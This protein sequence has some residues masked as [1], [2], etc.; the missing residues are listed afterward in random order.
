MKGVQLFIFIVSLPA[1][2]AIGFDLFLIITD[3]KAGLT[4]PG[5]VWTHVNKDSYIW[6][7][8]AVGPEIWP[9]I[10]WVLAQKSSIVSVIFAMFFYLVLALLYIMD[11]WPFGQRLPDDYAH[12]SR[13]DQIL[14]RKLRGRYKYKRK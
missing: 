2:A 10:S 12:G 8:K 6:V 1:I 11:S 4:T 7:A 9:Y 5:Y 13:T 3:P 14:E